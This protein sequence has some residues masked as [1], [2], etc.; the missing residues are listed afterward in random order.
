MTMSNLVRDILYKQPEEAEQLSVDALAMRREILG[1]DHP[2]VAWSYY[3]LAYVLL[4]R[5]K[6]DEADNVLTKAFEMRGPNLPDEHPVVSSCF[7]LLGRSQMN[8]GR[9][10][11]ARAAF[12]KCLQLR[13]A[14]LPREHWLISTTES[15]LGQCLVRSGQRP[16]GIKLLREGYDELRLKLGERHHQ[17]LQAKERLEAC[18]V[19]VRGA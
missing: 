3:N 17:T 4:E 16:P 5:G 19:L 15:F 18:T 6:Q 13:L 11:E 1:D 10:D 14:T 2:D 9:F 7:L 12:E 8:D